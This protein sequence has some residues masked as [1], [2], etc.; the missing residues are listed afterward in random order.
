VQLQTGQMIASC[1]GEFEV[2][3]ISLLLFVTPIARDSY[4]SAIT[5]RLRHEVSYNPNQEP[6]RS[7]QINQ[8]HTNKNIMKKHAHMTDNTEH[9]M[10]DAQAL[11]SATA[12]VA[13]EKVVEARKR[14][15]AAIE[16]GKEAWNAIQEKTIAGAKATDECI[17]ENP[18]KSIGIALGVGA[19]IGFLLSRRNHN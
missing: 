3:S 14:L 18:Y 2:P 8:T 10:E 6:S 7:I 12:H 17:R 5:E 16:K 19:L 1:I 11:L 15:T 4:K 13:E 9:L